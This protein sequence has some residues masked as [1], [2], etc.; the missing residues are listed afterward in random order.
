M[1]KR[2]YDLYVYVFIAKALFDLFFD[3]RLSFLSLILK[4]SAYT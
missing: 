3:F 1:M 4:Q 2:L